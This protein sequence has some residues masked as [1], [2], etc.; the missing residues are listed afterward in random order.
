[1]QLCRFNSP[2]ECDR[3]TEGRYITRLAS[4]DEYQVMVPLLPLHSRHR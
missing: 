1:M 4:V 2:V 3:F